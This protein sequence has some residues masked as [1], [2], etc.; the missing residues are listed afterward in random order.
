MQFTAKTYS[1]GQLIHPFN[2]FVLSKG[3]NSGKLISEP[4]PNCYQIICL[5]SE[6]KETLELLSFCL[7]QSKVFYKDLVGSVIPF[8]RI[9]DL[10]KALHE[11]IEHSKNKPEIHQLSGNIQKLNELE[12]QY[13]P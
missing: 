9:G 12:E 2:F 3:L 4:C 5:T 13:R 10:R 7:W 1:P 11:A 6:D 8:L